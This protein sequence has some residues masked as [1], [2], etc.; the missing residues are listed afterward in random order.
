MVTLNMWIWGAG[1]GA[2][3]LVKREVKGFQAKN[4]DIEV[5]ISL[6][7]WQN[8]WESIMKAAQEKSG[9]DILQVGS[10]WNGTLAS[11]GI[12]KDITQE[13]YDGNLSGDVFIPASW[14]S[15]H[16]PDSPR[17]SSLPWFVDIRALYYRGDIFEELGIAP[18]SLDK[19][20]S[21][22]KACKKLKGYKKG[23]Q[24]IEVLGVSGQKD[25]LLLHN[26]SPWIWS[27]GGDFLTPDGKQAAFNNELSLNGMAFYMSLVGNGYIPFSA[28]K[29]D[30]AEIARNFFTKGY[31]SM[32]VPGPLGDSSPL[33]PTN[34]LYDGTVAENCRSSLFPSGT[35]GR[36][37]FCG[38]SNIALT[39]FCAYPEEAWRFIKYMAS[40]ESQSR[41][42]KT[43]N[44]FPSLLESFDAV[45]TDDTP[46]WRGLKDVWRYGR[47]FPNVAAWG[48]IETLLIET[49]GKIFARV[50][51][52]NYDFGL[53][54]SDLDTA[55]QEVNKLLSSPG[56]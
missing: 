35:E 27:A 4:Q 49:F 7:P 17:I 48:A 40:Y 5:E 14:T 50:Q 16:F 8:A 20:S 2:K 15:C 19:W 52:G 39:S 55:A 37:S 22:D 12:L 44:M 23:D 53:V 26:V 9:P 43:L 38:G 13:V 34:P 1:T 24:V 25:A 32:G 30:T 47:A 54:K 56:K 36:Y 3:Q 33:D 29:I 42:P 10:T 6:I 45:F 28:L 46:A 51:E 11:M 21:F 18:D 31:Y 41:Y